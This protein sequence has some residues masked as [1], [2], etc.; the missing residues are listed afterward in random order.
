MYQFVDFL[1]SAVDIRDIQKVHDWC[2]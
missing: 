1:L 2:S